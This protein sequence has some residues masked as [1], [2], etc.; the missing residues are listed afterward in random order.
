M[1][2]IGSPLVTDVS[3]AILNVT[4]GQKMVEIEKKWLGAADKCLDPNVLDA[5]KSLGLGSFWGHFSIVGGAGVVALIIHRITQCIAPEPEPAIVYCILIL[6]IVFLYCI[7]Y[8]VN[9]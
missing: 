5:P 6:Q 3:W 7:F 1:F 9:G 8:S 2:P 4:E